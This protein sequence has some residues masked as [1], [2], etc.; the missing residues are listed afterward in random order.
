[1]PGP[2]TRQTRAQWDATRRQQRLHDEDRTGAPARGWGHTG[3]V[4]QFTT[5]PKEKAL[6]LWVNQ[7]DLDTYMR[8]VYE[9]YTGC[10]IYSMLLRR[11]LTL[12]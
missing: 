3:R 11:T 10:G 5:D 1:V 12:L 4:G 6:W 7:T 9:Y 2:S 8:D